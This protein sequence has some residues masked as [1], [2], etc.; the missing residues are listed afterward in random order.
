M[1]QREDRRLSVQVL[2]DCIHLCPWDNGWHHLPSTTGSHQV[3][4]PVAAGLLRS[5]RVEPLSISRPTCERETL[6][7]A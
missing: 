3:E 4:A 1:P 2:T 6:G 5:L 7:V